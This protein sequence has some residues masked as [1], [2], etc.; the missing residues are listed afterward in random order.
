MINVIFDMDGTLIDTQKIYVPAYEE[1]GKRWGI[2]GMGK[3]VPNLCGVNDKTCR[4]VVNE[5]FPTVD[6]TVFK[7]DVNKY[8]EENCVVRYKKGAKEL[9]EFLKA[10]NIKFG[11][12][13]GT[14]RKKLMERLSAV[15]AQNEFAAIVC[16][17]EV[18]NGK[19]APDIFLKTAELMGVDPKT[20]IVFEDSPLGIR[21][22]R[23]AGMKAVGIF[24]IAPFDEVRD[25]MYKELNHLGEAIKLIEEMI[26]S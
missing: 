3:L 8:V 5:H 13:S 16:G 2:E 7:E 25:L 18:E 11:L 17:G 21:A 10:K 4:Q 15:G 6:Y 26:N 1:S 12:A 19:P 9:I 23:A 20:C 24:D 14:G 22:A